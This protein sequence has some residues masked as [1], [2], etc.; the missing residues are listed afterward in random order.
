[1]ELL[2]NHESDKEVAR[3]CKVGIRTVQSTRARWQAHGTVHDRPMQRSRHLYTKQVMEKAWDLLGS[4]DRVYT[5]SQLFD[6]VQQSCL[7]VGTGCVKRFREALR[8]FVE[9]KG[10]HIN[11]AST[12]TTFYLS[13][14]DKIERLAYANS[15][16]QR[17][18][19]VPLRSIIFCDETSVEE[20]SHPKGECIHHQ[21]SHSLAPPSM[22]PTASTGQKGC[23]HITCPISSCHSTFLTSHP[24]QKVVPAIRV[25]GHTCERTKL[26]TDSANKRGNLQLLVCINLLGGVYWKLTTGTKGVPELYKDTQKFTTATGKVAARMTAAEYQHAISEAVNHFSSS[27]SSSQ[28]GFLGQMS[29]DDGLVLV[30][31]RAKTHG[32]PGTWLLENEAVINV[33]KAPPRSPDLMPLDYYLFGL[34]KREHRKQVTPG[35]GWPA[36][37]QLFLNIMQSLPID[38]AIISYRKRLQRC[39]DLDGDRVEKM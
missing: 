32:K 2:I 30:H 15:M 38:A 36:S 35:M 28:M 33:I 3:R 11:M 19:R 37:A 4:S 39:V 34:A 1:M 18:K 27:A 13:P 17:L 24:G 21:Q 23:A 12:T 5:V 20:L 29:S 10:Y 8:E 14:Q 7:G 31:D 26:H 16:L 25:P 6:E 9:G 22:H